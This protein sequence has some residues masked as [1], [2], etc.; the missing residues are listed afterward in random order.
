VDFG[1][2]GSFVSYPLIVDGRVFVTAQT[3]AGAASN[4]RALDLATGNVVWGPLE[5]GGVDE[6]S[7]AA[8]DD[9]RVY[10]VNGGGV[11]TAF[12]AVTGTTVWS[13]KLPGQSDFSSPP[14]AAGGMVFTG[15]TGLNGTV[16]GVDGATGTVVWTA[17]VL[18][19]VASSPALSADAVFVSY[20]CVQA[21]AFSRTDGTP[22][23]HHDGGCSGYG[24]ATPA[25]WQGSLW[26]RDTASSNLVL[27]A[28]SGAELGLFSATV[29]PAFAGQRG[30]FLNHSTLQALD[31]GTRALLWTFT[32]DGALTSAPLVVNEV[33]YIGST[34]GQLYALDPA[35]GTILWSDTLPDGV[36]PTGEFG[37]A[38]V[39]SMNAG[40]NAL[41]VPAGSHLV[42]YR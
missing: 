39:P 7:N 35:T 32:G 8:Y 38:P 24:G 16:Y 12:D 5:V 20:A 25:L 6:W 4:L 21:Y 17:D 15:G 30:F 13:K 41:V 10:V 19:G 36:F 28:T 23:W 26:A 18:G 31:V 3:S 11:L 2:S 14:T 22:I 34:N 1:A 9:G 40:G 33:V 27:D 29:I 37:L 42:C